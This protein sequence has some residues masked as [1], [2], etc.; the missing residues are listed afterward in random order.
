M[1]R[2]IEDL[3][4]VVRVEA[5]HLSIHPCE[6]YADQ[7]VL[8]AVD[9]QKPLLSAAELELRLELAP[10]LPP[11]LADRDRLLQV[12]ENLIGNAVKF[13][14]PGGLITVG[15]APQGRELLFWVADTGCGISPENLRHLF[16]RFWQARKADR[17]G[18]MGL[19]LTIAKGI[20]EAHEGRLWVES[21]VGHG[22][23]FF[24]TAPTVPH[25]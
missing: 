2:L 7:L 10:V 18:G 21:T 1:A 19:G 13:T 23:T 16:D 12:F 17:G 24:F 3:L 9:A 15:A 4:D 8:D 6:L 14:K 5:G 11:L 20:I 22:S 25:E